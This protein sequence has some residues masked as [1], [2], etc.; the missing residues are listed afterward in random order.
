MTLTDL[1]GF[2]MLSCLGVI[3]ASEPNERTND[4]GRKRLF[5]AHESSTF[6]I[7]EPINGDP[8][9]SSNGSTIGFICNSPEQIMP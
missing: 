3:G 7:A 6:S 5:Y 4:A 8:V 2:T 1:K 9:V